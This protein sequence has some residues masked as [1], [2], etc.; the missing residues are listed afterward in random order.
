MDQVRVGM[1]GV[2]M[3]ADMYFVSYQKSKVNKLVRLEAL[4]DTDKDLLERRAKESG[5]K[6]TYTDYKEMLHDDEIDAVL[7]LTPHHLHCQMVLD[8]AKAGKHV[9]V[10]KCFATTLKEADE[11]IAACKNAEVQL[12]LLENAVFDPPIVEAKRMIESGEVGKPVMIRV[13]LGQ[14]SGPM[15]P[16]N[17]EVFG[18]EIGDY[19]SFLK[20][21]HNWRFNSACAGGGRFFDC[22]HHRFAAARYLG[23]EF[24]E[25]SSMIDVI[26]DGTRDIEY[27]SVTTWKYSSGHTFGVFDEHFGAPGQLT[28]IPGESR[29]DDRIEIVCD[30][31]V[32]WLNEIEGWMQ[33]KAPLIVYKDRKSIY[34][35]KF[36][37]GYQAGFD[38]E[39][40]EFAE[41]ILN[42]RAPRC[43]GEDGKRLLQIIIA[44][45]QSAKEKRLVK[46]GE[47]KDPT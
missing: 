28:P 4:C 23:G 43:N 30:K 33:K 42:N 36:E 35:E 3:V 7:V 25:I 22:G 2:G 24:D 1:I 26:N 46:V 45:Y 41:A 6:K 9:A 39:N 31:G 38:Y 29:F 18:K 8:A 21:A 34:Y 19:Y 16:D 20:D 10:E 47:V 32:I 12:M 40:I 27:A 37:C 5:I 15:T 17:P 11:M 14:G 44:A 13:T